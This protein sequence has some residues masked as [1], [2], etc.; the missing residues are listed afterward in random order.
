MLLTGWSPFT[1]SIPGSSPFPPTSDMMIAPV[2]FGA[3]SMMSTSLGNVA[4][5]PHKVTLTSVTV[6]LRPETAM[7]EGYGVPGV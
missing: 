5:S 2:P 6:P 7:D 4:L 1:G 3:T